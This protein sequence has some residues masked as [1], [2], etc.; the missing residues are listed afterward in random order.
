MTPRA[1]I[2][3][4]LTGC[5]LAAPAAPARAEDPSPHLRSG[6]EIGYSIASFHYREPGAMRET[7]IL[8]GVSAAYTDHAMNVVMLRMEG[9]FLMGSLDYDG[10]SQDGTPATG[11]TDDLLFDIRGLAGYDLAF[12]AWALTPYLGLGYRYWYDDIKTSGGYERDVSQLYLPLGLETASALGPWRWGL[13]GEYDLL[14]AGWITSR[15]SQAVPGGNDPEN[16]QDFASGWG[17]RASVYAQYSLTDRYALALEP[18]YRYWR[19]SDS[20][21]TDL[22]VNGAKVGTAVEPENTTT[23]W[24]LKALFQF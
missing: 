6:A 8:H 7:G 15:L 11:G 16:E 5:L 17:T 13:R 2:A 19:V 20:D 3:L 24:G 10:R 4:L 22:T 14:L 18:Y 9:E 12:D 23:I 1:L 21:E